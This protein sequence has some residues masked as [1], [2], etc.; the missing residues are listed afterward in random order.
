MPCSSTAPR[1]GTALAPHLQ[2]AAPP[3]PSLKNTRIGRGEGGGSFF[4]FQ[5]LPLK[6]SNMLSKIQ[7]LCVP[8]DQP[9][10][11][12]SLLRLAAT[13]KGWTLRC[14]A[15]GAAALL[16][17]GHL[18]HYFPSETAQRTNTHTLFH[19]AHLNIYNN[20]KILEPLWKRL[21]ENH[22]LVSRS[23]PFLTPQP[24]GLCSTDLPWLGADV[25]NA[26]VMSCVPGGH[27]GAAGLLTKP[28]SRQKGCVGSKTKGSPYPS[29]WDITAPAAPPSPALGSVKNQNVFS[30]SSTCYLC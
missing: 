20:I 12:C 13:I 27:P 15:S 4:L 26:G 17:R 11:Q 25:L 6:Q 23:S 8:E 7:G 30:V 2:L 1:R 10:P 16:C 29:P 5:G 22:G 18:S 3:A 14:E 21:L 28:V 9:R 19:L 24:P